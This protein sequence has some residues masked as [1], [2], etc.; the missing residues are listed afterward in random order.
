M[1]KI[2]DKKIEELHNILMEELNGNE[3]IDGNIPV[4]LLKSDLS[5]MIDMNNNLDGEYDL[6]S[7][8][9]DVQECISHYESLQWALENLTGSV[10]DAETL[11]LIKNDYP[12]KD[13]L[14]LTIRLTHLKNDENK[15]KNQY[16]GIYTAVLT[17]DFKNK[18][19]YISEEDNKM[20][21]FISFLVPHIMQTYQPDMMD[22]CVDYNWD[23]FNY[24]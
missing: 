2:F 15:Y 3:N 6:I 16:A 19:V 24:R 12:D 13:G 9:D 10:F 22:F 23:T 14:E 18:T 5:R 7:N 17:C 1:K 4:V 8:I 11:D 21:S 20:E